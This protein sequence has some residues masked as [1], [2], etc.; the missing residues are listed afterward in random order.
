M[1]EK[2]RFPRLDRHLLVGYDHF[3][4]DNL[5]D[6]EGLARTLDMSVRGLLLELP[7][8]VEPGTTLRLQLNLTG[9]LIEA[10]GEVTRCEDADHNGMYEVGV[11]LKYVPEAFITVVERY[12]QDRT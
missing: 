3:N 6:D 9:E 7:R 4:S 10:F 8:P 12:F 5:K 11:L 1:S 2:R